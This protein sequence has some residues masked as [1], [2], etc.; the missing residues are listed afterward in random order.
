MRIVFWLMCEFVIKNLWEQRVPRTSKSGKKILHVFTHVH[1]LQWLKNRK[2]LSISGKKAAMLPR[3]KLV[4]EIWY[5]NEA[6]NLATVLSLIHSNR[7][8]YAWQRHIYNKLNWTAAIQVLP[9]TSSETF[10]IRLGVQLFW[11]THMYSK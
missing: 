1:S 10:L 6:E 4:F 11:S 9:R 8:F 7:H 5:C 3:K 2:R